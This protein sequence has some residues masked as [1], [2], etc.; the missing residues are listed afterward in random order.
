MAIVWRSKPENSKILSFRL[1]KEHSDK[2]AELLE[3][4]VNVSGSL[5][6]ELLQMIDKL[7]ESAKKEDGAA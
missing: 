7:W 1:P 5:K 4:R 3:R 2:I 6:P